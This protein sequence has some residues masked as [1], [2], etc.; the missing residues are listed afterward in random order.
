[1]VFNQLNRVKS[2]AGSAYGLGKKVN[3]KAVKIGYKVIAYI[4]IFT[5]VLSL[6]VLWNF[7]VTLTAQSKYLLSLFISLLAG[8]VH[9]TL[10]YNKVEWAQ[11][12]TFLKEFGLTLLIPL[13]ATIISVLL[14]HFLILPGYGL[15][16]LFI[17]ISYFSFTVPYLWTKTM[18][19]ANLIPEKIYTY[20]EYPKHTVEPSSDWQRD[21]FVYANLIFTKS[22]EDEE[23]STVKVRMPLDAKF[24]ELVYLFVEDYNERRNPEFPIV[25]LHNPSGSLKWVFSVKK[26]FGNRMVN[27]DETVAVNKLKDDQDI[28]FGRVLIS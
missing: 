14:M 20:W 21:K 17:C 4:A 3:K 15:V 26:R 22:L 18:R 12:E 10:L 9:I 16:A 2:A 1:M 5:L 28:Y 25:D 23:P 24:G 8:Y 19:F 13:F 7:A 11:R 6:N 27:P